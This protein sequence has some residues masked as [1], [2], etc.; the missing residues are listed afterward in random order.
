MN[1][2]ASKP[3]ILAYLFSTHRWQFEANY[4]IPNNLGSCLWHFVLEKV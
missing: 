3:R 1:S 2:K 4:V